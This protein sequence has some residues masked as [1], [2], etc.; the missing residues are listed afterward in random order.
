MDYIDLRELT[1]LTVTTVSLLN[2]IDTA[3]QKSPFLD[4]FSNSTK[5]KKL[6]RRIL[7]AILNHPGFQLIQTLVN[8]RE[9]DASICYLQEIV[10]LK[11][12]S[13]TLTSLAYL[14][15]LDLEQKQSLE[16]FLAIV[17]EGMDIKDLKLQAIC[18]QATL[19]K[20]SQTHAHLT[21][22]FILNMLKSEALLQDQTKTSAIISYAEYKRAHRYTPKSLKN[23]ELVMDKEEQITDLV[24][25]VITI[26]AYEPF[27]RIDELE[28]GE[29]ILTVCAAEGYIKPTQMVLEQGANINA[30]NK[31]G[32]TALSIAVREKHFSLAEFLL[33]QGADPNT[34]D[35]LGATALILALC[36]EA[37]FDFIKLLLSKNADPN[38]SANGGL[39]ALSIAAKHSDTAL[40]KLLLE[41]EAYVNVQDFEGNTPL[42]H[43]IS[44]KNMEIVKLLLEHGTNPNTKN[45]NGVSPLLYAVCGQEK[46][47]VK[48]L[49]EYGARIGMPIDVEVTVEMKERLQKKE[50][51]TLTRAVMFNDYEITKAL[52]DLG[53]EINA[54]DEIGMTALTMAVSKGHVEIVKLLLQKGADP[55][56]TDNVG[57]TPLLRARTLNLDDIDTQVEIMELLS[58]YGATPIKNRAKFKYLDERSQPGQ[59]N[60]LTGSIE[61]LRSIAEMVMEPINKL[62]R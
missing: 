7:K 11:G 56:K 25:K 55:N 10:A 15:E 23:L 41:Y 29:N 39:T 46:E 34:R 21:L 40:V 4:K 18:D 30:T 52:L 8:T 3:G 22:E 2:F 62:N 38:I 6:R 37:N 31:F 27:G 47:I 5:Y 51:L 33:A 24:S 57:N 1:N 17:Y 58:K 36:F 53:A 59:N 28:A 20:I 49:I 16:R 32:N 14:K 61:H 26:C 44:K 13:T 19:K 48:L 50:Q 60:H 45:A 42:L 43:A 9:V 54:L 35:V 12:L